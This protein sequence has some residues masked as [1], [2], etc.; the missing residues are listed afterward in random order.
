MAKQLVQIDTTSKCS[1]WFSLLFIATHLHLWVASI[2]SMFVLVYSVVTLRP[3]PIFI[4]LALTLFAQQTRFK[5]FRSSKEWLSLEFAKYFKRCYLVYE[6]IPEESQPTILCVHPHGVT[7]MGFGLLF[8]RPELDHMY[9]C[10]SNLLYLTPI[11]RN[12]VNL[13]G[14]PGSVAKHFLTNLIQQSKSFALIPGGFE[15]AT[16][17]K[18]GTDR[19][20]LKERKGFVKLALQAGYSITP[21]YVFG[22]KN[23]YWNAQGLWGIRLRLNTH[24]IPGIFPF[25]RWGSLLPRPEPLYIAVG[26]PVVLPKIAYPTSLEVAEY[27]ARYVVALEQLFERHKCAAYGKQATNLKL[28]IW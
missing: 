10:F 19:I 11:C 6:R 1:S 26:E 8:L 13:F 5:P 27:H 16:I 17:F 2:V 22:E 25:G 21:T 3:L 18:Q 9:F 4:M 24:G 20:Y 15:D 12:W 14:N 23:M 28:E 7:S